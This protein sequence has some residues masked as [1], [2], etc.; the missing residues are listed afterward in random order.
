MGKIGTCKKLHIVGHRGCNIKLF[1][2]CNITVVNFYITHYHAETGTD[3]RN[4]VSDKTL[5]SWRWYWSSCQP[6]L[7][8][9][10]RKFST[11]ITTRNVSG[12]GYNF[13]YWY[14][15]LVSKK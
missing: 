11:Y 7:V 10:D 2:L 4:A 6:G 3:T 13:S 14:Q 15:L 9:R 8:G 5:I 1:K 12:L